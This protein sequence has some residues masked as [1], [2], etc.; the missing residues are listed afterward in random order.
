M[1]TKPEIVIRRIVKAVGNRQSV[2]LIGDWQEELINKLKENQNIITKSSELQPPTSKEDNS[3]TRIIADYSGIF[4]VDLNSQPFF[5]EF[6]RLLLPTGQI[7]I[8]ANS[9][10]W[11]LEKL[12]RFIQ[13]KPFVEDPNLVKIRPKLLQDLVQDSGFL[14]DTYNGYPGGHLL[15]I[16]E[17]QN[18]EV[19]TLFRTEKQETIQL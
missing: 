7:I 6:R 15:M 9:D 11:F 14:I 2:L 19:T 3:F 18:K 1:I 10:L 17:I 16:A 5:N 13:R 4:H 8:T 12:I